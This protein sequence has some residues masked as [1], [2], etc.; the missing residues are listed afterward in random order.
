M[1]VK[2]IEIILKKFRWNTLKNMYGS[3][4]SSIIGFIS[5][6]WIK[7]D[8]SHY[9]LDG[10]PSPKT[11]GIRKG[12]VNADILLFREDVPFAVVEVE[13]TI[14]KYRDKINTIFK[15]LNNVHDFPGIK[16]GLLIMTN[17]Y[18][19]KSHFKTYQH[20]WEHIK[21][22]IKKQN[23]SMALVSIEKSSTM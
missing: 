22:Q 13:T 4:H 5:S 12:Q 21:Q 20:N 2:D 11:G 18:T 1:T 8:P 14:E 3:A 17:G 16:F 10:A 7:Q 19:S 9:V 23:H 6:G 15:Y